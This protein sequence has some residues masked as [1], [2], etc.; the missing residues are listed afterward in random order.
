MDECMAH[1]VL[2]NIKLTLLCD[3][4]LATAIPPCFEEPRAPEVAEPLGN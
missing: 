1:V 2:T 4:I 3:S